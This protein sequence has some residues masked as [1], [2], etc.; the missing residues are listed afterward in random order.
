[1][2]AVGF[3]AALVGIAGGLAGVVS[4]AWQITTWRRSGHNVRVT[5]AQA[6]FGYPTGTV[7]N[8]MLAVTARNVGSAAVTVVGWG[9][10]LPGTRENLTV[11]QPIV[12]S[13]P[14]PHRLEPGDEL[15]VHVA[16]EDLRIARV[17]RRT[18]F[19]QMR[20]WVRLGSGER[21]YARRGVQVSAG[22]S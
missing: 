6:W 9:I 15:C 13:T 18:E 19:A 5:T 10:E 16:A 22:R 1:M 14:I 20:A 8:D 11:L 4:L 2:D 17:E 7:S 21:I 3:I 12:G